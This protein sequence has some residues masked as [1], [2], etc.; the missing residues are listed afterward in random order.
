MQQDQQ[1]TTLATHNW[2]KK[3]PIAYMELQTLYAS[4]SIM[5]KKYKKLGWYERKEMEENAK[6]IKK[7]IKS[8]TTQ[9]KIYCKQYLDDFGKEVVKHIF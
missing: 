1:Q 2:K 3:R 7:R 6:I 9:Y 5:R 4:L 8:E